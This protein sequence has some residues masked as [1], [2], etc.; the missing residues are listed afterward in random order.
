MDELFAQGDHDWLAAVDPGWPL[1]MPD[2]EWNQCDMPAVTESLMMGM[3]RP[4][5][6]ISVAT[7]AL[8]LKRRELT[9]VLDS[10]VIAQIAARVSSSQSKYETRARQTRDIAVHLRAQA[11]AVRE[12]LEAIR[13]YLRDVEGKERSLVRVFDALP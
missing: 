9:P 2:G 12:E 7:K 13:D 11:A 6:D 1:L 10:L 8:H 4:G 5:I 3:L